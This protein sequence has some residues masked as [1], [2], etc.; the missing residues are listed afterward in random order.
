MFGNSLLRNIAGAAAG[1]LVCLGSTGCILE[2]A[3]E[4]NADDNADSFGSVEE[5]ASAPGIV[6]PAPGSTL[7]ATRVTFKWVAG[8]DEYWLNVGTR[9]GKSDLYQSASLGKATQVMVSSLPLDG[10]KLYVQLKSRTGKKT[11]TASATYTASTRKGLAVI[12]DFSDSKLESYSGVGVKSVADVKSL[13]QQMT[14]HWNWLSRGHEKIQWD[15]ARV[16]LPQ[17]LAPDAFP[18]SGEYR[19]AVLALA[20]AQVDVSNYDVNSDG[21]LDAV[22]IIGSDQGTAP[23][24]MSGGTAHALGGSAFADAQGDLSLQGRNYGNFNHENGHCAGLPDLYGD[25]GTVGPLTIMS[26]SWALPPEDFTPYER[27]KLG[28]LTPTVISKTTKHIALSSANDTLTALRV[29]TTRAG[30]YFLIEYRKTPSN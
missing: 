20:R 3:N 7:K 28:W 15:I 17:R 4:G 25:Y 14:A 18:G 16:T 2:A 30:E 6:A 10:N 11:K 5:A 12:A 22:W 1:A 27:M 21:D 29:P 24:Y 8:A 23:S 19:D 26:D 9:S 13:L